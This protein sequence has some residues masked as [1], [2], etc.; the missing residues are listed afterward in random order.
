MRYFILILIIFSS[1]ILANDY[2][3]QGVQ[4]FQNKN[5]KQAKNLFIKS[6]KKDSMNLDSYYYLMHT[7]RRLNNI[8]MYKKVAKE[9][10]RSSKFFNKGYNKESFYYSRNNELTFEIGKT[11]GQNFDGTDTKI[12]YSHNIESN[13][14]FNQ[15]IFSYNRENRS[16]KENGDSDSELN[17]SFYQSKNT[18]YNYKFGLLTNQYL[19]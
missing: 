17:I 7:Y 6:I 9:R 14:N 19:H 18:K 16:Y 12:I 11:N 4:E 5:F 8:K 15:L 13:H 10:N 2:Y 1:N 3:N